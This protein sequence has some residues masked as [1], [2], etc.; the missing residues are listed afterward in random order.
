MMITN[1]RVLLLDEITNGLDA[2]V[3]RDIVAA[4]RQWTEITGGT[5]VSALLQPTPEV[6]ALFDTLILLRQGAVVYHGPRDRVEEYLNSLGFIPPTD[7][8]MADFIID[9]LT[10]PKL[11]LQLQK[12]RQAHDRHK[13]E[14][15]KQSTG[16]KPGETSEMKSQEGQVEKSNLIQ[17]QSRIPSAIPDSRDRAASTV[18]EVVWHN[19]DS[20]HFT[21]LVPTNNTSDSDP[22]LKTQSIPTDDI[23]LTQAAIVSRWQASEIYQQLL[24]QLD[25]AGKPGR[26][27]QSTTANSPNGNNNGRALVSHTS[28]R[29]SPAAASASSL[30][31]NRNFTRYTQA[32]FQQPY[33]HTYWEHTVYSTR[34]QFLLLKRDVNM[35]PA[36]I[37]SSIFM[38]LVFGSLFYQLLP[39]NFYSKIGIALFAVLFCAFGNFTELPSAEEGRNTIYKQADSGFMPT[40]SYI[41]ANVI[42]YFPM[43]VAETT[44]FG[45]I[46]YWMVG[47]DSDAGR[48]FFFLFLNICMNLAISAMFRSAVYSVANQLVAQQVI[49]PLISVQFLFGGF[50]IT[51]KHIQNWLI[52]F[53]YLS[54]YSWGVTAVAQNEF[55]DQRYSA[56]ALDANGNPTG[57]TTGNSDL[58]AFEIPTDPGYKWGAIGFLIGNFIVFIILCAWLLHNKR[59]EVQLGTKRQELEDVEIQVDEEVLD[60]APSQVDAAVPTPFGTNQIKSHNS[61]QGKSYMNR[62]NRSNRSGKTAASVLPFT[63]IDLV[64]RNIKYTIDVQTVEKK[65]IAR[66][67][68]TDVSGFVR[69]GQLVA[70][71]GSSGAGKTTLMDVIAMRKTSGKIEGEILINGFPQDP[72]TFKRLSGYVEQQDIHMGLSTVRESLMFSANLRLPRS[73]SEEQRSAFVDEILGLLEM[74]PLA[75]RIVGNESYVGLSPGQLKLLT[76]GTELVANPS[77]LFLDEVITQLN[78]TVHSVSTCF[79]TI[80]L[81]SHSCL[82]LTPPLVSLSFCFVV[83]LCLSICSQPPV[84]I[85][86]PL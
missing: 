73:T 21:T 72:A 29:A 75:D 35:A 16:T 27:T 12:K 7:Q 67:L 86:V 31:S 53:Y 63:P 32:Q 48:Y 84:W 59:F 33:T 65:T 24:T 41:I 34:R 40:I 47:F 17:I 61:S 50:L 66:T 85:L 62:S 83:Y 2:A 26:A 28:S 55:Q 80:Y 5:V 68:L 37:G 43:L 49:N 69:P 60:V 14:Q 6:Y 9:W 57:E 4:L 71:M 23:P 10:D 45:T 39:T 82:T 25:E 44:L 38:A 22:L 74:K 79:S 3:A 78:H 77:L 36:R 30:N 42:V 56:P 81:A 51:R 11:V 76:I 1:A 58:E 70:L 20:D 8:D 54:P 46:L 15:L 18:E 19:D 52:E 13:A 64:F